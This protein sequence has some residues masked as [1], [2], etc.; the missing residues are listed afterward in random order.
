MQSER[1]ILQYGQEDWFPRSQNQVDLAELVDNWLWTGD[2][3]SIKE[4]FT[5][6]KIVNLTDFA[7]LAENWMK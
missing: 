3:G 7:K 5:G 1:S 2:L 4:D 6:D